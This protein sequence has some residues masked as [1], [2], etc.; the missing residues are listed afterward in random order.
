MSHILSDNMK[1]FLNL[2]Q[3]FKRSTF[4][5]CSDINFGNSEMCKI[6]EDSLADPKIWASQVK[7]EYDQKHIKEV[8]NLKNNI[9]QYPESSVFAKSLSWRE[10]DAYN[11]DIAIVNVFFDTPAVFLY[12]SQPAQT[13]VDFFAAIGGL[14]GLCFG[15]SIITLVEVIWLCLQLAKSVSKSA[16]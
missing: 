9:R 13:W 14:L 6:N 5:G 1:F 11:E 2:L 12:S 7:A 3:Y 10:Y 15:F 8:N 16:K 4:R